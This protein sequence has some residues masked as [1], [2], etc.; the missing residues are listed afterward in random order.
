[1][2]KNIILN[3]FKENKVS[4]ILGVIFIFIASY[5]QAL[6]PKV[7]GSTIDILKGKNFN[8]NTVK[9]NIFLMILIGAGTFVST[10]IW[11]NLVIAN[12]RKLE[13]HLREVLYDHF[14]VLSPEFYNN[15]KTGDLIAY[16]INDISAVRM[17]FGPATARSISGVVLC[18]ASIYSMC[19]VISWKITALS[20]IPIPFIVFFMVKVG[21]IVHVRF[22][23]VQENFAS[24]SDRIQ[25]NIYGMRVIKTYVQ[26]D[27]ELEKF[28]KL[29]SEMMESNLS[30]VRISSI[31]SPIIEVCFSI[32]FVLNLIVGGNMVLKNTITLGSFIAFNTYLAMIMPP[33]IS[34]G[35]IISIFQRGTASLK[36]L[37]DILS[38]E[39]SVKNGVQMISTPI[40]GKIQFEN[41]NFSY[42]GS[43]NLALKDINLSIPQGHTLGII[44]KTGSGKSTLAN[45]LLKL[46][47]VEPGK[48]FLDDVDIM[49][50]S[51]NTLRESIGYIPQDSF[52]FSTSIKENIKFFKD[53]YS[54]EQISKACEYSSCTDFISSF[55]EGID[56]MLGERGVNLSGGQKQRLSIAR[57]I[58][59]DPPILIID[60]ALSAVD[61]I[62]EKE[63]L[64]NLKNI[65]KGKTAIL[66]AHKISTVMDADEI[67]VLD[68]GRIAEKGTHKELIVKGGLYFDIF[69]EQLSGKI[70]N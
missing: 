6:F 22:K 56:T 45:I 25:E 68:N 41:L 20:L 52:L 23:K 37:E 18:A 5:V 60:D 15:R 53:I 63:I 33:I 21:Q 38:V 10:Y 59:K 66:I 27:A 57:A 67:I 17:T 26:E 7:L 1:M 8:A 62:T 13:C 3:F 16:S 39:P 19:Q 69:K 31:L 65:R 30:M 48:V 51:L 32:S 64:S 14:Q 34:I 47:N 24:I 49:D 61:S 43:E 29:N 42:P 28:E 40:N 2:K 50:Y 58:I 9:F 4:Y 44:G 12:A 70:S 55:P 54:D 11:R 46:Y 36:R 35:R